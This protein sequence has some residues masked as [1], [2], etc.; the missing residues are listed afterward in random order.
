MSEQEKKRQGIYDLLY[1]ESKPN[2]VLTIVYK[3]KLKKG[4]KKIFLRKSG[5]GGW[6]KKKKEEKW[7]FKQ[8]S[9]RRLRRTSRRQ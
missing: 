7:A 8:L 2:F 3:A 6:N 1:A 9:L 4:Q 5:K